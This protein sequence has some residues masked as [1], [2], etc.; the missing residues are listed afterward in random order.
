MH[1][2]RVRFCGGYG[3]H[4]RNCF[5]VE[6]TEGRFY[7]LDCGI[8]DTDDNPY[9][10]ISK[11]EIAC[12]D[13]LF[14][15]HCH[16]DHA[17]AVSWLIQEGFLGI[18]VTTVMTYI[19]TEIE[20]KRVIFLPVD[21]MKKARD[22]TLKGSGVRLGED[23]N[24]DKRGISIRYGRSGHCP[25]SLWFKIKDS[26]KTVLY[27]GDYQADSFYYATDPIE[28]EKADIAIID[29]A[30]MESEENAE[31]LRAKLW[32]EINWT[33]LAGKSVILP[34]QKY[35]RGMDMRAFLEEKLRQEHMLQRV[36]FWGDEKL[37]QCEAKMRM[38]KIWYKELCL[39]GQMNILQTDS[40]L[41]INGDFIPDTPGIVLLADTHLENPLLAKYVK[42]MIDFG[43]A[44]LILTGRLKKES[45][46]TCMLEA[47][48]A[49]HCLYPHHQSHWDLQNMIKS[50]DFGVV[51]PF[52]NDSML[53]FR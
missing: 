22:M 11:D 21:G 50:N 43:K 23:D 13:Y 16:K 34:V 39:S 41:S 1:M 53:L 42:R 14:L 8:M 17:G 19:L 27:S 52:H 30:H 40:L 3:E 32:D 5:L 4:G 37:C 20:Y 31:T 44:E 7:M 29:C 35:G 2:D 9:P 36:V 26:M 47:G 28:E 12:T 48:K 25:G 51:F 45:V 18:L 46:C 15:S 33:L 38:E 24:G 6:Y 49:K 10:K